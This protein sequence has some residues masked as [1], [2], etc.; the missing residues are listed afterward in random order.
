MSA[1]ELEQKYNQLSTQEPK[2]DESKAEDPQDN[3]EFNQ[4]KAEIK[5]KESEEPKIE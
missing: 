5:N 1:E 3:N 2:A 4:I